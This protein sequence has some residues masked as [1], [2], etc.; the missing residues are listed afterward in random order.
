MGITFWAAT[1]GAVKK[2]VSR[3]LILV[4]SMGYGVVRP[5]LGGLTSKVVLL[6]ST[7]FLAVEV[8]DIFDPE[9]L[10]PIH[11]LT[12][13]LHSM[14]LGFMSLTLKSHCKW[15]YAPYPDPS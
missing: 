4:V 8:L 15:Q 13:F 7:Y 3:L 5:T 9:H 11:F 14:K 12:P 2:T 6:G 10:N 1:F